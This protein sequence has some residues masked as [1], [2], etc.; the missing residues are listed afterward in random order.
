[1]MDRKVAKAMVDLTA[2]KLE[3]TVVSLTFAHQMAS[4]ITSP[5][6]AFGLL[7]DN[8]LINQAK[9]LKISYLKFTPPSAEPEPKGNNK[10]K[11]KGKDN[12]DD[13]PNILDPYFLVEDNGKGWKFNDFLDIL[14]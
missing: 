10:A 5:I 7:V 1:M 9:Q 8:A 11:K 6:A 4:L 2:Q 3:K 13:G 14:L 12:V